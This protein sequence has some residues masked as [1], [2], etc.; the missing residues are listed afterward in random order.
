[1]PITISSDLKDIQF[2]I[3]LDKEKAQ[4]FKAEKPELW[5]TKPLC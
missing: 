2:S 4:I 1:M 3:T 5:N